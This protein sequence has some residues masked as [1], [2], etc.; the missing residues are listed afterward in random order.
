MAEDWRSCGAYVLAT[1][2]RHEDALTD[3]LRGLAE[4][5]RR[6]MQALSDQREY[7]AGVVARLETG[8]SNTR[9]AMDRFSAKADE[10]SQRIPGIE[11]H[12]ERSDGSND[13]KRRILE[14]GAKWA[15]VI[16]ALAAVAISLLR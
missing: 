12:Q 10:L 2:T 1:L 3:I 7:M 16:V 14:I 8:A 6:M 15:A 11:N 13:T 9:E 4:S 5:D